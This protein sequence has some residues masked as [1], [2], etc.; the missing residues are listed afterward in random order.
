VLLLIA[1]LRGVKIFAF[2]RTLGA[3][4]VAGALFGFEFRADLSRIAADIRLARGGVPLYRAVLCRA[5]LLSISRRTAARVAM[6]MG[7][8]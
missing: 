1:R 8:A 3:G 7:S 4:L 6:G 5:G 2:R